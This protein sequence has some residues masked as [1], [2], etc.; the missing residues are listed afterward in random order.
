MRCP[1]TIFEDDVVVN[2]DGDDDGVED[3]NTVARTG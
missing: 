2:L 3:V 1:L